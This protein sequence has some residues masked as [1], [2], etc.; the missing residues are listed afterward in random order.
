MRRRTFLRHSTHA[1]LGIGAL[2]SAAC[3]GGRR[4][5]GEFA[6][7]R[8]EYVRR[9]LELNPVTSTYLGGDGYDG[10]LL[11]ANGRLRDYGRSALGAEAAWL[12]G[13][14]RRLISVPGGTLDAGDRIDRELMDA[15]ALFVLRQTAQ[16]NYQ[17]RCIDTYVA[18]PFRG[19]DW[20]IQ[21]LTDAGSGRLGTEAEWEMVV[22][23]LRAVRAYLDVARVNLE[24][25][26]ALGNLPDRRMVQRDGIAGSEANA[27]YFRA[28]LPELATRLLGD[29]P[30]A[31][32]M[33]AQLAAAGVSAGDEYARFAAHLREAYNPDED[34]TDR[35]AAGEGEYAW[36]VQNCLRDG[37]SP[38]QLWD[39]GATQVAQ[40]EEQM[41]GVAAVVAREAG[42]GLRFDTAAS[43]RASVR[44]VMDH[45]SRDAPGSDD[46]LFQWYRDAGA[47]AVAYGREHQLFDIPADYRLD[48]VPTPPVLRSTIDAAYYPAPPFKHAGV[49][50]F[51]LTP[52]GNDPA[53][54]RLNNRASVADT[55]IH[56]GFP[57]HDWHYKYMTQHAADISP[58]RW[59]TPGAVEDSFSMWADS[60]ASEG[61]ALYA[62][63]LMAEPAPGR[64]HGFYTAAEHLYEIQGQLL[65]AV[66]V[67]VDVGLHTRRMSFDQAID[68][69]TEHVEF[70]PNARAQ[71]ARNPTARAITDGATRAIYR[72][73]KWPTQA[74][75]YNVGKN[76][77]VELRDAARARRGADFSARDFHERFM[78]LGAIPPGFMRNALLEPNA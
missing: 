57:G 44:A 32:A 5:G 63:E 7:L 4:S 54:L 65:R 19:V 31:R 49:G 11:E 72:Y 76:A 27:Q 53:A 22:R 51:Y 10:A 17:Q 35:F 13:L 62:E 75:T 66:R 9:T 18:E 8:S 61:W 42:L 71:A 73:S 67:R 46:E 41:F 78:R 68:Y 58:V 52:T 14:Q 45:L 23:R 39:Y 50:R 74:I 77:I 69:F 6:S 12:E 26:R 30:F 2:A 24:D 34:V 59:I 56:E 3:R 15:Q 38:A 25:G 37:R 1:A 43:R 64:P 55:A 48:V 36:R 28:T 47:R 70:F 33:L 29:R 21:Q 16:Y 40:Y 20:Q 60:M